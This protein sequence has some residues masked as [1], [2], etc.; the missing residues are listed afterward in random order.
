[1]TSQRL[2]ILLLLLAGTV[3]GG[4]MPVPFYAGSAFSLSGAF[5]V[6]AA[7][8]FGPWV[9]AALG[10]LGGAMTYIPWNNFISVLP[11][12]LEALAVGYAFRMGRSTVLSGVGFWVIPGIL[13]VGFHLQFLTDFIPETKQAI[14]LKYALNGCITILF[15]T[16]IGFSLQ[17]W[18]GVYSEYQISLRS[19]FRNL[20]FAAITAASLVSTVFWV[21]QV[22]DEK[23]RD[24]LS[25]LEV[26]AD[27]ISDDLDA[28]VRS[29]FDGFSIIA[30]TVADETLTGKS[31]G[32]IDH[33]IERHPEVMDAS[34]L[35]TPEAVRASLQE[36]RYVNQNGGDTEHQS[37]LFETLQT[38]LI[39]LISDV[40][41]YEEQGRGS[42]VN[43]VY[44]IA[45]DGVLSGALQAKLDLPRLSEIESNLLAEGQNLLITDRF[46]AVIYSSANGAM[47]TPVQVQDFSLIERDFRS[48]AEY[49]ALP[50]DAG[51]RLA[52]VEDSVLTGWRVYVYVSQSALER[53][54][55][56][57]VAL[58]VGMM[59]LL[60]ASGLLISEG[61]A[62]LAAQPIIRLVDQLS[63]ADIST[64]ALT[65]G[66]A[67]PPSPVGE[68][69]V[70]QDRFAEFSGR[71][72]TA[73]SQVDDE[74]KE[75]EALN[76]TLEKLVQSRTKDLEK[77]LSKAELANEAKANFLSVMSHEIR[78]PMTGLIGMLQQVDLQGLSAD[79]QDHIKLASDS[80]ESLQVLLNDILDFN[81]IEAGKMKLEHI[82]FQPQK[83]AQDVI[84]LNQANAHEK[85]IDLGLD[86]SGVQTKTLVG[87]PVRFRQIISNLISNAI[88][89]TQKGSVRLSVTTHGNL[90]SGDDQSGDEGR[91]ECVVKDTG[92]GIEANLLDH[93]FDRFSQADQTTTRKFGGTGLG[94]A[95]CKQLAALMGGDLS[96]ESEPGKGSTFRF[97]VS[98]PIGE[99][100]EDT[101]PAVSE[102]QPVTLSDLTILLVEDNFINQRLILAILERW[103]V[104]SHVVGDGLE[105]LEFLKTGRPDIILSDLQMPNLDGL[106]M[107]KRI[108]SGEAGERAAKLPIIALTAN[109]FAEDREAT[110]RAGMDAFIS[111]PIDASSLKDAI[112][113][114]SS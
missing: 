64:S 67:G 95:I 14:A 15:G 28:A 52:K 19:M 110:E 54:I 89:F 10:A 37:D 46:G 99:D 34:L 40:F 71:L 78:T 102:K 85:G 108:R 86:L 27:R 100:E 1:M 66:D 90:A 53:D 11:S 87:D 73:F 35:T 106:E 13:I 32:M 63:T 77:A 72:N 16:G 75:R 33:F 96:V 7:L 59:L 47:D 112:L 18:M 65:V 84:R 62:S 69:R 70:L 58:G 81:K 94:L 101:D 2:V 83:I 29:I 92:I 91:L 97:E 45:Q 22:I 6:A 36:S 103:E 43:L 107:T 93:I 49:H 56:R 61:L 23:V 25:T 20:C 12:A 39:P 30:E 44:P 104:Q 41:Q 5:S 74:R 79:T 114:L 3:L 60:L 8:V 68:I 17:R 50:R 55:G 9:G 76:A 42:S 109:A 82:A 113:R 4:L 24:A 38:E 111:K 21:N 57:S 98:L 105:A 48:V 31:K 88:K 51:T 80:A 26:R